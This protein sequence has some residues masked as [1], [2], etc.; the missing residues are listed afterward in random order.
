MKKHLRFGVIGYGNLGRAMI[1]L[2]ALKREALEAEGL[3]FSLTCVLSRKGGL[4]DPDGL[5]CAALVKETGRSRRLED[6]SGFDPDFDFRC[7]VDEKR[8][9]VVAEFTPTDKISGEPGLTHIRT[10]LEHGIHVTTGNKGPVLLAWEELSELAFR[11]GLLMGI[12]CTVGGALPAL[13]NGR[14]AMSGSTILSIE[15]ILNGTTNFILGRM[16]SGEVAYEAALREAQEAGI[17]E[18]NPAQDVEGWDTAIKL[19]ILAKVVMG[20][21]LQLDELVVRGIGGVTVGD[22]QRAAECGGRVK[23]C[24]EGFGGRAMV[25]ARKSRRPWSLRKTSCTAFVERTRPCV[26]SPTRWGSSS[27]PEALPAPFQQ[28]HRPCATSS[29]PAGRG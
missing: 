7:M 28:L 4:H 26:I 24:S 29:M 11:K 2:L 9:D 14:D 27:L 21:N 5:D 10:C 16:E 3:A 13:I 20:I 12:G 8:V 22:M 19:L 17:A 18:T 23:Y 1:E 15:G 25:S 6:I